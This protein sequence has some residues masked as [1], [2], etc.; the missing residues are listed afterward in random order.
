MNLK[1]A[2]SYDGAFLARMYLYSDFVAGDVCKSCSAAHGHGALKL[3]DNLVHVD[4]EALG[5]AAVDHGQ[6]GTADK[7]AVC[8]QSQC[9]E[10]INA[11]AD[12]AVN[13]NN[14]LALDSLNDLRQNL[15]GG[16]ASALNTAAV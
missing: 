9:A 10:H 11:G 6:D 5:S 1:K 12:A 3:A 2:P 8:A 15:S 16:G 4:I 14:G 13:Q 7:Y